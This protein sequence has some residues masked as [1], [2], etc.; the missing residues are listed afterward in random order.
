MKILIID[1]DR[2][3]RYAVAKILRNQGHEV[4]T[5]DDGARG[6][7]VVREER[8][9]LVITDLIMPEQEG[10]ETLAQIRRDY[11]GVKVIAMSGGLRDS[12]LDV[13]SMAHALGAD[14]VLAK[15]FEEDDLLRALD[16]AVPEAALPDAG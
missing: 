12:N 14:V 16:R 3:V 10:F 4:S 8:P 7:V 13:L 9:Q 1:D 5:A 6:M 11:P 15:P 2:L